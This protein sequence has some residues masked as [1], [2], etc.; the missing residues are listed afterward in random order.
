MDGAASL[1]V[2]CK[3]GSNLEIDLVLTQIVGASQAIGIKYRNKVQTPMMLRRAM[4]VRTYL[5]TSRSGTEARQLLC[6][7]MASRSDRMLCCCWQDGCRSLFLNSV[8]RGI[9]TTMP[10]CALCHKDSSLQVRALCH[11]RGLDTGVVTTISRILAVPYHFTA[12]GSA[13]PF[14][15]LSVNLS[16]GLSA[17]ISSKEGHSQPANFPS[18]SCH[19]VA[20]AD[21]VLVL[22][23][24]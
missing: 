16:L 1:L 8:R 20:L 12:C 3:I 14:S 22:P 19:A 7:K 18:G 23:R 4:F 6:G 11:R 24:W 15:F 2:S 21:L 13:L 9:L 17:A 5:S 10:H